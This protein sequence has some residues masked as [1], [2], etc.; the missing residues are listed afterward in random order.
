MEVHTAVGG[1]EYTLYVLTAVGGKEYV[2]HVHT[3]VGGKE[4]PMQV[5]TAVGGKEYPM[6]VHTASCSCGS[7]LQVV[8]CLSPASA[9]GFSPVLLVT[10]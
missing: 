3:A 2:L 5:H 10:E 9:S 6:Q 4:Y 8:S 1:K 7:K